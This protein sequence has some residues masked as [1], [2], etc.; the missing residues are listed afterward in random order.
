[1]KTGLLHPEPHKLWLKPLIRLLRIAR[2][3]NRRD[4]R[5]TINPVVIIKPS[6]DRPPATDSLREI[7]PGKGINP[8]R[9]ISLAKVTNPAKAMARAPQISRPMPRVINPVMATN[10]RKV[11]NLA[12]AINPATA[13]VAV[14]DADK[15]GVKVEVKQLAKA[16]VRATQINRPMPRVINPVMVANS[17]KAINLAKAINPATAR[18]AARVVDKGGVRVVGK[19][20]VRGKV[21]VPNRGN[22]AIPPIWRRPIK[23]RR[24]LARTTANLP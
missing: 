3:D 22:L 7:S 6:A 18:V 16:M 23:L 15:V 2:Q 20:A 14:R 9:A 5:V 8:R 21:R 19:A 4:N 17:R 13:K 1:M 24:S 12:K 10:W 11:I